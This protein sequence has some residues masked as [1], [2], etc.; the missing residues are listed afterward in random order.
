[1]P[2]IIAYFG[3]YACITLYEQYR[4]VQK[5]RDRSY[6]YSWMLVLLMSLSF[7]GVT[8][9]CMH[10]VALTGV[11]VTEKYDVHMEY[12]LDLTVISLISAV[13]LTS[14]GIVIASQDPE[15]ADDRQDVTAK[16]VEMAK[17]LSIS[18]LKHIPNRNRV[19][20]KKLFRNMV[21]L[22][23]AAFF[24]AGAVC[25][26]HYVG[27][28]SM[29]FQ[30]EIVWNSGVIAATVILAYIVS[31]IGLWLIFR[32]LSLY[33]DVEVLR[34]VSSIV[35]AG[36]VNAVHYTAMTGAEI[37]LDLD[38][39]VPVGRYI[40]QDEAIIYSVLAATLFLWMTFT[41]SIADLRSKYFD[42][43]GFQQKIDTMAKELMK[44]PDLKDTFLKDYLAIKAARKA[45]ANAVV[46][47]I[48]NKMLI[49]GAYKNRATFPMPTIDSQCIRHVGDAN[50]E[51]RNVEKV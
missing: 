32:L 6:W 13:L 31:W 17:T 37:H 12:R 36:A 38:K 7:G 30:G 28:L 2:L 51:V 44:S 39:Y 19:I 1:M 18:Q 50:N 40:S 14:V 26:M 29:V 33:P 24:V 48:N 23:M 9:W 20:L 16:F 43:E 47:G 42:Y 46:N 3:S 45:K 21:Q 11:G 22:G 25:V 4:L 41:L 35:I 15:F 34:I 8:I 49:L 10:Y 27:M 5:N